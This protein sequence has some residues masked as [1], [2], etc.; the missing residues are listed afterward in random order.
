MR[1]FCSPH[2]QDSLFYP[3]IGQL[4]RAAGFA[5]DRAGAQKPR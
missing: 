2:H 4:E 1:Y 3:V 5:R